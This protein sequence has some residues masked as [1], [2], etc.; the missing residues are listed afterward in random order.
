MNPLTITKIVFVIIG[1][2]YVLTNKIP[3]PCYGCEKDT[4]WSRCM[5]GTGY[6]TKSCESHKTAVKNSARAGN[7]L[8]LVGTQ[9]SDF[10][11]KIWE[12]DV[13]ELPEMIGDFIGDM[14]DSL[15]TLKEKVSE[16]ISIVITFLQ[17]K[18]SEIFGK[19]KG[20]VFTVYDDFKRIVLDP[21]IAFIMKTIVDPFFFIIQQIIKFRNLVWKTLQDAYNKVLNLGIFDFV[22]DVVDIVKNIPD[23]IEKV[24]GMVINLLNDMKGKVFTLLNTGVQGSVNGVNKGVNTISNGIDKAVGKIVDG[25][26]TVMYVAESGVGSMVGKVNGSINT[27]EGVVNKVSDGVEGVINKIVKSIN[28]VDDAFENAADINIRGIGKPL[29]FLGPMVPRVPSVNIPTLDIPDINKPNFGMVGKPDI[30]DIDINAPLIKEPKDLDED[31]MNLPTI[32]GFGFVSSKIASLK[33]SITSLFETAMA[34]LYDAIAIVMAVITSLVSGVAAFYN[35]YMSIVGIKKIFSK[36][37]SII[38][39]Q[40][41]KVVRFIQSTVIPPIIRLLKAIREPIVDFVGMAASKIW[42][43]MKIVGSKVSILFK[44][45]FNIAKTLIGKVAKNVGFGALYALGTTA[46]N[47]LFFI[48]ASVSVKIILIIV[49]LVYFIIGPHLHVLYGIGHA[50]KT[51]LSTMLSGV[52]GLDKMLDIQLGYITPEVIASSALLFA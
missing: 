1:V 25:I 24:K 27:V 31:S 39:N 11:D 37:T 49:T 2:G 19:I 15:L 46:D 44:K 47:T 40:V 18:A 17:E 32:P 33:L 23:A 12:F 9:A 20:A 10:I 35:E 3:I 45:A 51:L 26:N 7:F 4:L 8:A 52:D 38:S 5:E 36:A 14:K 21:I 13:S 42:G 41:G 22:G 50:F 16:K 30:P 29:A 34:P 28:K 48:P 43:F 6:G